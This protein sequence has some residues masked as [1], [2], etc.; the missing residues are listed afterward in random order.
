M[1]IAASA[2][3]IGVSLVPFHIQVSTN[4]RISDEYSRCCCSRVLQCSKSQQ[5]LVTANLVLGAVSRGKAGLWTNCTLEIVVGTKVGF[6][7]LKKLRMVPFFFIFAFLSR[8]ALDSRQTLVP[9]CRFSRFGRPT[10][11]QCMRAPQSGH[12]AYPN[13]SR[14]AGLSYD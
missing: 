2:W 7:W 12:S 5:V 3:W 6:D 13:A 10:V 4:L 11:P 8:F 1:W 9:R 14:T